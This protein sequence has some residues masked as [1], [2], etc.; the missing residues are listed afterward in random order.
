M[1]SHILRTLLLTI[2][3]HRF[4]FAQTAPAS[5]AAMLEGVP[6]S[7]NV[8]GAQYPRINADRSVTFRVHAPEARG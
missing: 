6:A 1:R 7:T 4:A 8:P 5:Q 2:V 3:A